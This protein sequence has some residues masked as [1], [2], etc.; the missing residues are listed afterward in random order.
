MFYS[1]NV[2]SV[3]TGSNGGADQNGGKR[4]S[5]RLKGFE[6]SRERPQGP[7]SG[8]MVACGET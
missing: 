6:S 2:Y 4:E 5:H 8:L 1:P 7:G 3:P